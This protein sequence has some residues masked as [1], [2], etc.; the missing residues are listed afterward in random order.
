MT[1]HLVISTVGDEG[2][3]VDDAGRKSVLIRR[4]RV[5]VLVVV[6]AVIVAA[7]GVF[8]TRPAAQA[9]AAERIDG[10]PVTT[11]TLTM[12]HAY[13]PVFTNGSTDDYHCILLNPH[14]TK[15]SYVVASEFHPGSGP[16]SVEVHHAILFLVPPDEVAAAEANNPGDKGWSCFGE[17]PIDG[18]SL[19]GLGSFPWLSAWAPG[20]GVDK[21]PLTTGTPLPAGSM[22]I[23]QVHFNGLVGD[24]PVQPWLQLKTVPAAAKL[25]PETLTLDIAPPDY[26]CPTGVT[27]PLC[28]RPA[29]LAYLGQRFGESAVLFDDTIESIC[30]R[31][32]VDPPTSDTTQCTWPV[33][34][35][36]YVVRLGAHM[37]L[38]GASMRIILNPGTPTQKTLLDVPDFNFHY[39][40]GYNL[41]KWV[42][43]VPGDKIEVSCTYNPELREQLPQL[44]KLPPRYVV[45]GDGSSDEMCLGLVSTVPINPQATTNWT[46]HGEIG[47]R[48]YHHPAPGTSASGKPPTTPKA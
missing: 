47:H 13:K 32:P 31:N 48:G 46:G 40:R 45:W 37:H 7:F 6:M 8:L 22:V 17:S 41:A 19:A 14:V 33:Y 20:A 35:P 28:S 12:S 34:Q 24:K 1:P 18:N 36:G 23:M 26:G 27:G 4:P 9:A 21:E 5:A 30:G 11:L 3:I 42:K 15:N 39:Q 2:A 29:A 38:T 10:Q 25:R 43:V 44:R 16:S